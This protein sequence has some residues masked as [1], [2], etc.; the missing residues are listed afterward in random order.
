MNDHPA[1]DPPGA[2]GADLREAGAEPGERGLGDPQ[3]AVG[4]RA[5][6]APD[7]DA[8]RRVDPGPALGVLAVYERRGGTLEARAERAA[9][10]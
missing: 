9:A 4:L 3:R 10:L 8:R 6:G 5:E 7:R 1:L 2:P